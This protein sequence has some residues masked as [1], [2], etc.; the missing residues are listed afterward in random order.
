VQLPERGCETDGNPQKLPYL[1][2]PLNQ[3]IERLSTGVFKNKRLLSIALKKSKGSNSPCYVQ[4]VA[5]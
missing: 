4:L 3:T 1:H 5:E 2:R